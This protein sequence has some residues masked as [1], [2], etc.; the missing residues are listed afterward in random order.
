MVRRIALF[1][2]IV[3]IVIQFIQPKQNKSE[4]LGENDISKVYAMPV[5]LH[6]LLVNKCYDCHSNNTRNPWYFYVQPVGWWLAAHVHDG[7]EELNFSEFKT[8]KPE[9]AEHKLEEFVEVIDDRSMPLKAYT[10]LHPGTEITDEDAETIKSWLAS[11]KP[12]AH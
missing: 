4:G 6:E 1:L 10:V 5:E 3:L 8:Y 11:I 2:L 9:R 7:K 12:I